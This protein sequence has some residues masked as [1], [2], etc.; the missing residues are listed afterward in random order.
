MHVCM[1]VRVFH[2]GVGKEKREKDTWRER[3]IQTRLESGIVLGTTGGSGPPTCYRPI[4][5]R[6]RMY[7]M[8]GVFVTV[9]QI[10]PGA[11]NQTQ[12]KTYEYGG[13]MS[14]TITLRL[15]MNKE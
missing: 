15:K 4:P 6:L 1:Y 10:L 2:E 13:G 5:T 11:R 8:D 12:N 14:D 3:S 9:I 7:M